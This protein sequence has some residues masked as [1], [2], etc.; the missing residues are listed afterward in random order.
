M[1]GR[2]GGALQQ[3]ELLWLWSVV[4]KMKLI[5]KMMVR[6]DQQAQYYSTTGK[7]ILSIKFCKG[8]VLPFSEVL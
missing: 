8:E 2:Q 6:G 3:I 1:R 5:V 7:L 4:T